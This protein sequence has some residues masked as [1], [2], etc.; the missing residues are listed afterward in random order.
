MQCV[1]NVLIG[2]GYNPGT[3]TLVEQGLRIQRV[4]KVQ[5]VHLLL[6]MTYL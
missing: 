4:L 3:S 5:N 6:C 1:S 2:W